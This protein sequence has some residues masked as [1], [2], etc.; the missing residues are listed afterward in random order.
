[1]RKVIYVG[2]KFG[3]GPAYGSHLRLIIASTQTVVRAYKLCRS[4]KVN[5]PTEMASYRRNLRNYHGNRIAE[6]S[7]RR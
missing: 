5:R 7:A 6:I 3:C 1:V 4:N 2:S